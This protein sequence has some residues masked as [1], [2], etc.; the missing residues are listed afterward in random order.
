MFTFGI[1]HEVAFA[2]QNGQFADYVTTSFAEFDA[3]IAQLPM[4]EEDYP[5][6]RVGDAGIRRKRWYI[7]C[8]ERFTPQG[9]L[10]NHLS[11]GIEIRTTPHS[12]IRGAV[13]ELTESFHLL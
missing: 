10:A 3:I 5:Y 11:K 7:E 4:Y 9:L 2:H 6:L 13:D 12:T 1:E 8:L